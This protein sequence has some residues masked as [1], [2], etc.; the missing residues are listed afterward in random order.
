MIG[1]DLNSDRHLEVSVSMFL[2]DFEIWMSLA[3]H[4]F[5]PNE[6]NFNLHFRL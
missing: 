4:D 3:L 5:E 2:D 1:T 6:L